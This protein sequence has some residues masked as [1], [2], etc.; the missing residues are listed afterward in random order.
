METVLRARFEDVVMKA[1]LQ[2]S[3]APQGH[4]RLLFQA[5]STPGSHAWIQPPPVAGA[6]EEVLE[7]P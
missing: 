2:P 7:R 4:A 5:S 3:T 1:C 6:L